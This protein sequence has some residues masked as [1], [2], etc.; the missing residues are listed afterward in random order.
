MSKQIV[1]QDRLK[2]LE[3]AIE[4]LNKVDKYI[5][6]LGMN[7]LMMAKQYIYFVKNSI[8]FEESIDEM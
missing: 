3:E 7:N 8:L 1:N 5:C 6:P 4:Y 2:L